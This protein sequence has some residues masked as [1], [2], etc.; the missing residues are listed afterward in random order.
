MADCYYL[1]R[2][3][4]QQGPVPSEE[5]ARLIRSG[6]IG[7]DTMLWYAGMAEWSPAG[8]VSEFAPLFA[9][10]MPPRNV[11]P[12]QH[13]PPGA[14]GYQ[15]RPQS[16]ADPYAR[17]D[18]AQAMGFGGAIKTCF[19][20]YATFS[21]RARRP[22]YWW[23][24]LFN[25]LITVPLAIVDLAIENS[26]GPAVLSNLANL[27]LFLPSLAVGVRRLHDTDRRG[28][29]ILLWIIP[30]IGWIIMIVFLCERG[31][32]GANRFGSDGLSVAAEF[33]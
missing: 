31:T 14:G 11:P 33:D 27:A 25:V 8:Q 3:R 1:D 29:W 32:D 17:Y 28:W 18:A 22:E 30:L 12:V 10:A 15:G 20:K 24:A 23:W 16:A 2:A 26:G 6:A 13:T 7:R 9:Q 21:G 4:N 19:R 5:I